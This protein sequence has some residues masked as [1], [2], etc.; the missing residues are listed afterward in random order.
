MLSCSWQFDIS[1][2]KS[3]IMVIGKTDQVVS[4]T[5]NDIPLSQVTSCRDLRVTFN[6]DLT[7]GDHIN[8]IVVRAHKP[9]N[10]IHRCVTSRE[11]T[12]L[13]HAFLT[14]VRSLYSNTIVLFG[15]LLVSETSWLLKMFN[16]IS[17]SVYL[18]FLY[19]AI[20]VVYRYWRFAFRFN[21][22][23]Y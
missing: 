23:L 11:V 16:A 9:A 15:H 12:L 5:I 7:P 10:L 8:H 2:D 6:S 22:L 13:V 17:Q 19:T 14:Y 18:A 1:V 20:T 4:C 3:C 21:L